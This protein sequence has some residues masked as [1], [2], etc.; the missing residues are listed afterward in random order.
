MWNKTSFIASDGD[1]LFCV[2]LCVINTLLSV[3]LMFL[4]L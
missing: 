3:T 1:K 2:L 4:Y